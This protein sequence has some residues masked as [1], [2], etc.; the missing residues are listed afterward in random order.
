MSLTMPIELKKSKLIFW[1]FDGVIKESV[2]VKSEAFFELFAKFGKEIANNILTHHKENMG[3]SRFV[4]I[5][6][7]L[8]M[9]NQTVSSELT[10][11]YL[12]DFSKAVFDSVANCPWVP[13]VR[14]YLLRYGSEKKF[15]LVTA[16][17]QEEIVSLLKLGSI[18][19]CFCEIYGAPNDKSSVVKS[20]LLKQ[21]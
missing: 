3:I 6:L 10:Q 5:P 2:E 20:V 16:T 7:Y 17:P 15:I 11:K 4:K 9:A 8:K 19:D 13:G 21:S 14:E 18:L 12:E 1:D